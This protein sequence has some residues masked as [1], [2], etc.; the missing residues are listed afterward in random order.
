MVEAEER[1]NARMLRVGDDHEVVDF[2]ARGRFMC[3]GTDVP[4]DLW[5]ALM[6]HETVQ[7]L[8]TLDSRPK[9]ESATVITGMLVRVFWLGYE[10]REGE[11]P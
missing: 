8:A 2:T 3:S 10:V 6:L 5:T 7:M 9:A 4:G 1:A 11:R